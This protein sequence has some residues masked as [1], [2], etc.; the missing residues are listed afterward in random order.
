MAPDKRKG[1]TFDGPDDEYRYK[2]WREW[3]ASLPTVLFVMLNPSTAD[4]TQLDNTCRR[5]LGYAKEWDYGQLLV[6]NLFAL[7]SPNPNRLYRHDAPV[8]PENDE[9]LEALAEQAEQVVFAWGHHGELHDRG[10]DV[11][12]LLAEHDPVALALTQEGHPRHPL[13]LP[14][15]LEPRPF[16]VSE[17][18]DQ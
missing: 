10:A 5:C 6:G 13:Y 9:H 8:G 11:A 18:T 17:V 7:R 1:A 16:D 3:D 14:G 4:E 15:D 2:L 12:D